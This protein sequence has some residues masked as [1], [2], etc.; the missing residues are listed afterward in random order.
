LKCGSNLFIGEGTFIDPSHCF[1][2]SLGDNVTLSSKVHI[3][4]HDASTKIHL[5]Y[6]KIGQVNIGNNVFIGANVTILPNIT[7]GNNSVVGAGSVVTTSIPS[8]EVWAGNP[9]KKIS[10]LDDY[11]K[12]FKDLPK[13]D[14]SY[15]L[16][17]DLSDEKKLELYTATEN[18][19]VLLE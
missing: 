17:S 8:N 3:L 1:L 5:G 14:K 16:S 10:E 15:I 12:K 2:I 9:A 18:G 19:F 6:T 11:L 7:I 4:A 13:F